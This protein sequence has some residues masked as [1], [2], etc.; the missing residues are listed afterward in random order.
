MS[1]VLL[2][3]TT[4]DGEI[5]VENGIVKLSGGLETAAYLSIFGGNED[6]D[7]RDLNPFNWWGNI[8]VIDKA[9]QYHSKTQNLLQS[10]PAIPNNLI[11]I[12]D[13]AKSDLKW[14]ID[15]K[16]ASSIEVLASIPALNKIK[17]V[18]NI[19]ADGIES[20]FEFTENWKA[21]S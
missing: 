17:L 13:A 19:T 11:R 8:G 5:N 7:G 3:Q 20:S 14:F 15:K 16:V 4:D 1:D 2:F 9:E 6:D 18:I 21:G 10:I 12:E